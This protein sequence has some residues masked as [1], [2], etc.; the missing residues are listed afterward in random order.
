[1][2]TTLTVRT[3]DRLRKALE[4]RATDV[5]QTVSAC[6]REILDEAVAERPLAQKTGHLRGQL[7]LDPP[8]DPWSQEL[9]ERNWRN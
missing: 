7:E 9:A 1:M 3:D 8:N 6:V 5:G 4:K 2:S